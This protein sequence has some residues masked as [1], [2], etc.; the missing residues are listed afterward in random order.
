MHVDFY[1]QT[2]DYIN[3]LSKTPA[4][5]RR[6]MKQQQKPG[7]NVD[8]GKSMSRYSISNNPEDGLRLKKNNSFLHD[9]A[10]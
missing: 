3:E 2:D 5:E 10:D 8:N 9:K 1:S 6:R 7:G 4:F